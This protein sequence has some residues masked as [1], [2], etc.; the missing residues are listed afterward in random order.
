MKNKSDLKIV[1]IFSSIINI[2]AWADWDRMK[3]FTLYLGYGVKRLLVPENPTATESFDAAMERLGISDADLLIK[4]K[5][6]FRLSTLML[7]LAGLIL[8]YAGYH[9]FY[10]AFKAAIVS[11][12][13]MLI[14][15]VLA[16]RYHFWYYQMKTRKLGCTF[17]QWYRFGLMGEK[18]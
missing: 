1:R 11:F 18:E 2:R 7:F 8:I 15:L 9:L 5:A 12:V 3:S 17:N 4:Q 6:L 16:F 14:A 13:V 10:G